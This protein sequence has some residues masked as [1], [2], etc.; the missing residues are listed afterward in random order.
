MIIL[1]PRAQPRHDGPHLANL[2]LPLSHTVLQAGT[3]FQEL[4]H[5]VQP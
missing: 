2:H 4:P 3:I 1:L 5:A